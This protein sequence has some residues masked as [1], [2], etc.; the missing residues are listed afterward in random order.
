MPP[1]V[2]EHVL[3][4]RNV[5]YAAGREESSLHE[6]VEVVEH[7]HAGGKFAQTFVQADHVHRAVA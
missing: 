4:H 1:L 3:K 2:I 6:A 7:L 5:T